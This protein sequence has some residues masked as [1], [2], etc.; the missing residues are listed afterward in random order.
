MKYVWQFFRLIAQGRASFYALAALRLCYGLVV[1]ASAEVLKQATDVME[2]NTPDALPSVIALAIVSTVLLI[3]VEMG[4]RIL[5]QRIRNQ[6]GER[7]QTFLLEKLLSLRKL[8]RIEIGVGEINTKINELTPQAVDG[9][10]NALLRLFEGVCVVI[11]GGLYMLRLNVWVALGFIVFNILFRVVTS[12]LNEKIRRLAKRGVD[13]GNRNASMST[14]LLSNTVMIRV[15]GCYPFFAMNYERFEREDERNQLHAFTI[16]IAYDELQ[17]MTKK[18]SEFLLP[19][20]LGGYLIATGQMTFAAAIAF[21]AASTIFVGGCNNLLYAS[22][23]ANE[24]RARIDSITG[25]LEDPLCD[26]AREKARPPAGQALRL[27][28]VSFSFGGR[29]ILRDVTLE[30]PSGK[31]VQIVGENGQGKSTL[32]QLIAGLYPPTSGAITYGGMDIG[33]METLSC[34]IPQFAQ[35]VPGTAGE[36]VAL[37]TEPDLPRCEGIFRRLRIEGRGNDPDSY[38]QGEKQRLMI[39]RALY[40]LPDRPLVLGDEIFA[41]ID[42]EN[43]AAIARVLEEQTQGKT[44]LLVCHEAMGLRFDMTLEVRDGRVLLREGDAL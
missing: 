13:I 22:I 19:F 15:F 32:L 27:E 16:R 8:R 26:P 3:L 28:H 10:L 18:L 39:G 5:E 7:L 23:S 9:M 43:R 4:S 25:F 35:I 20:G 42:P 33:P 17:W 2:N 38:S 1:L 44:L 29:P 36:N 41:N 24:A 40:H 12:K 37:S 11:I 14:E 30:I 21:T 6:Y 31:R 34:L